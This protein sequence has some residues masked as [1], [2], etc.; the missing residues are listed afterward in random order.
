MIVLE[1]SLSFIGAGAPADAPSWGT[2]VADGR[3]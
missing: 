3:D 2:L 1:S